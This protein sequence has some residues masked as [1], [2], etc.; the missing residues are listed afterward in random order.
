MNE[1]KNNLNNLRLSFPPNRIFTLGGEETKESVENTEKWR[2]ESNAKKLLSKWSFLGEPEKGMLLDDFDFIDP[3][4]EN[5]DPL[6]KIKL[7][8][9][10]NMC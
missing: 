2:Q 6:K 9:E 3:N 7:E 5:Y 8:N 10:W 4:S 1:I